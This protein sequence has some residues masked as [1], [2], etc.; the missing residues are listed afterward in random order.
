MHQSVSAEEKRNTE[1]VVM[2]KPEGSYHLEDLGVDVSMILK[3]L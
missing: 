3:W 1:G 2:G